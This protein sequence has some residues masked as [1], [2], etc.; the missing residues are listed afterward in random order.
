MFRAFLVKSG[1]KEVK[2]YGMIFM[3]CL[4]CA[5]HI[6]RV[7]NIDTNSLIF[8]T[9]FFC[10]KKKIDSQWIVEGAEVFI[11]EYSFA[12]KYDYQFIDCRGVFFANVVPFPTKSKI[13][14]I[15]LALRKISLTPTIS[16]LAEHFIVQEHVKAVILEKLGSD[17]LGCIPGTSTA[18]ALISM[19][20]N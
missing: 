19:F 2:R 17:Q 11:N 10:N 12:C 8:F 5:V 16:K 13:E 9:S 4:I 15:A 3:R 20:H 1:G 6:Q 7:T 18:D 14:D